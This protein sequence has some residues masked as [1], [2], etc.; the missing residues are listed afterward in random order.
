VPL[1]YV[2]LKTGASIDA[3]A[4]MQCCRAQLAG[5]KVP[6]D[7]RFV[8]A[9]AFPRSSTGKIQRHEIERLWASA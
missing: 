9:A 1:A 6:K 8:E 2:A 4:L 3:Q 7:I 5:Y